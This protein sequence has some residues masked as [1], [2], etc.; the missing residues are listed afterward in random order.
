M[1]KRAVLI[2]GLLLACAAAAVIAIAIWPESAGNGNTQ[3]TPPSRSRPVADGAGGNGIPR[4]SSMP[5]KRE[6]RLAAQLARLE[7]PD[8]ARFAPEPVTGPLP[9]RY[10][11]K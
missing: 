2:G 10:R 9:V 8:D 7:R 6:R 4:D 11:F 5:S 3:P 1:I